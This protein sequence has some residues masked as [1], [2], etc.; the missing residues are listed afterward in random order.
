MTSPRQATCSSLVGFTAGRSTRPS[1]PAARFC[2]G[3]TK[4][5]KP[6]VVS[7]SGIG[8][9]G[10]SKG[11]EAEIGYGIVPTR[12][13]RGYATEAVNTLVSLALTMPEVVA[14]VA[15]TDADNVA[16]QR[17]LERRGSN[18]WTEVTGVAIASDDRCSTIRAH[19]LRDSDESAFEA[20]LL[21]PSRVRGQQRELQVDLVTDRKAAQAWRGRHGLRRRA[22]STAPLPRH[23]H[24]EFLTFLRT[25]EKSPRDS[26][27]T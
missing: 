8:F 16:S 19:I 14:V 2:G 22:V 21:H 7:S 10:S 18:L 11:G 23:R 17:V 24:E 3:T 27:T 5:S 4:S 26:G 13:G 9:H 12:Q 1:A 25:T 15:S 6:P 20:V